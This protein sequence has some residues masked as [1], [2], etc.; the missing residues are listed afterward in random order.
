MGVL[1]VASLRYLN[2]FPR[3]L[4]QLLTQYKKVL[5]P[6]LNMGQLSLL[7]RNEFM[8]ETIGLNKVMGKPFAVTEV[9]AKIREIS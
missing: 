9:C 4:G 5:V 2:P 8:I 7:L 1:V 3:N 6:E